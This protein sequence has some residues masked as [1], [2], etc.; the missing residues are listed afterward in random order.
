MLV[1]GLL[2]ES[3]AVETFGLYV[4]EDGEFVA[5]LNYGPMLSAYYAACDAENGVVPLTEE[6]ANAIKAVGENRGWWEFGT[7]KGFYLFGETPVNKNIAWLFACCV[8]R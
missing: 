6:L 3:E 7:E 5:K 8:A 2:E 4:Y 1:P